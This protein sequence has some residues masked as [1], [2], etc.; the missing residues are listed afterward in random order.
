MHFKEAVNNLKDK[1]KTFFRPK[2]I[3][4]FVALFAVSSVSFFYNKILFVIEILISSIVLI[5]FLF[6]HSKSSVQFKEYIENLSLNIE[7]AS[8]NS[9]LK[10]PFPMVILKEKGEVIWHNKSF[11]VLIDGE[12][13]SN[14]I[15]DLFPGFMLPKLSEKLEINFDFNEKTFNAFGNL[16]ESNEESENAEDIYVYYLIETT[17]FSELTK[18]CHENSIVKGL[19]YTDN[20]D[21][22]T[23]HISDSE[24]T[25][26]TS[27]IERIITD[28]IVLNDGVIN[29]FDRDRY[30]F[31]I[32]RKN[33]DKLRAGKFEIL[34]A[35]KLLEGESSLPVTLSIGV[36]IGDSLSETES[37]TRAALDMALGRGG[38]QAVIKE[39]N[40]FFYFGGQNR[41]TEK[42]AKVRS[43]I[44]A[45]SFKELIETNEKVIIMGHKYPDMDLLGAA[46]GLAKITDAYDKK[47]YIVIDE[48][49]ANTESL[50]S[51]T[52]LDKG[53]DELF[54]SPGQAEMLFDNKT[55]VV[56]VDTHRESLVSAPELLQ[57]NAQIF[58]IDHHRKGAD[59]IRNTTLTFH[60]PY[61]S[62]ASELVV[63]M[64]QYLDNKVKLK[65][66]EA[67][68]LYV[69]ILIDT[70]NF[71]LRTGVRTFEAASYLRKIGMEP[72]I[73]KDLIKDDFE[74]YVKVSEIVK[75]A[76]IYDDI[77]IARYYGED[78]NTIF[79][80]QAADA[81]VS[82]KGVQASFVIFKKQD[83]ISISARSS[84]KI[85]VQLV[86][87]QLGGGGHHLVAG[88]RIRDITVD[89]AV[90]EIKKALNE[91]K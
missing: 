57:D 74:N 5:I 21:E 75:S 44:I 47:P 56:I 82:I 19:I 23:K 48:N 38:D 53:Y 59:F 10:A 1:F 68:A 40:D 30:S 63:E 88:T 31:I 25:V 43:R 83:L 50:F 27:H 52:K 4:Y 54:I 13:A 37:F 62:S 46:M 29:K 86:M 28:Y 58:L 65:R 51:K 6:E 20:I 87:E 41:E 2:M 8:H 34:K 36:G 80:A 12:W 66:I 16:V 35:V 76:E 9:V 18:R 11:A 61:A 78:D 55:L 26:L 49:N 90:M 69:G 64:L 22:V 7:S 77:A 45:L 67:E 32:E 85:N 71:S 42:R 73:A 15:T 79:I 72:L 39:G 84:G 24:R 17:E 3:F 14:Q 33:F 60:E 70:Q 91:L 81:L 89:K